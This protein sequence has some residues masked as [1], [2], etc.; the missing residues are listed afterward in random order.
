MTPSAETTAW[1]MRSLEMAVEY[2]DSVEQ[3][4]SQ[5]RGMV[6][7][8]FMPAC[9]DAYVRMLAMLREA[10]P[11]AT[12]AADIHAEM[13]SVFSK[14][15]YGGVQTQYICSVID[16]WLEDGGETGLPKLYDVWY[17]HATNRSAST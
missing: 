15:I 17:R 16:Q 11:A 1:L 9:R 12:L 8:P 14:P 10:C 6:D 2:E 5:G 7:L 13:L 3:D 4:A